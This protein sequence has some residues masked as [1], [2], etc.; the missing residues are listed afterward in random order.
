MADVA[1]GRSCLAMSCTP[2]STRGKVIIDPTRFVADPEKARNVSRTALRDG[3]AG[4]WPA[5]ISMPISDLAIVRPEHQAFYRRC[6]CMKP[7]V[8]AAIVSRP[9]QAGR[10]D[11]RAICRRC[12]TGFPARYPVH[13]FERFRTADALRPRRR[14]PCFVRRGGHLLRARLDRPEFLNRP[15]RGQNQPPGPRRLRTARQPGNGSIM[16]SAGARISPRCP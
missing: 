12:A 2:N 13:A 3:A 9:R 11:G 1:V 14:A 7:L 5:A 10:A 15:D 8:R 16:P 4:L 6:S